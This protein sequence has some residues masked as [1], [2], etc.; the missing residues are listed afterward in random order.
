MKLSIFIIIS[1]IL[2]DQLSKFLIKEYLRIHD[3]F[4]SITS[5]FN[6]VYA[7][8]TGVSFSLFNKDTE[9]NRWI[10]VITTALIVLILIFFWL[11]REKNPN[12]RLALSF[13]IGGALGNIIDRIV[14]GAV[15]DFLDFHYKMNHWPAFNLADSL[16]TVGAIFILLS[17]FIGKKQNA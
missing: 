6:V 10:L 11:K 12:T 17:V 14:Y 1:S 8:N 16:I 2:M 7:W 5:Y 15:F 4:I 3:G 13:I 9:L